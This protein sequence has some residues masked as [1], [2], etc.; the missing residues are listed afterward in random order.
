MTG[1]R[2][3]SPAT[4]PAHVYPPQSKP[5]I[6]LY[7]KNA[8]AFCQPS[9]GSGGFSRDDKTARG[10]ACA[11]FGLGVDGRIVIPTNVWLIVAYGWQR[12]VFLAKNWEYLLFAKIPWEF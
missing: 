7:R 5:Q 1:S 8:D 4:K 11:A 12:D 6:V 3:R 9:T 2:S 10:I